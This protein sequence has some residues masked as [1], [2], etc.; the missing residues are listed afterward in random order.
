M[1]QIGNNSSAGRQMIMIIRIIVVVSNFQ[2]AGFHQGNYHFYRIHLWSD[3]PLISNWS[4]KGKVFTVCAILIKKLMCLQ[5]MADASFLTV[6]IPEEQMLQKV[7]RVNV[8]LFRQ[9]FCTQSKEAWDDEGAVVLVI[10]LCA[11]S[12]L[13]AVPWLSISSLLCS[14]CDKVEGEEMFDCCVSLSKI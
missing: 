12:L 5:R 2:R 13:S 3:F 1:E 8:F 14:S 4:R 6:N 9:F 10:L 7:L 11:V